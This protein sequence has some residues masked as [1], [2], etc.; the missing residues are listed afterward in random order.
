VA[1]SDESK[2]RLQVLKEAVGLGVG[3]QLAM[4]DLEIRGAGTLLGEKQSGHLTAIG[5][6]LY[7]KLLDRNLQAVRGIKL[8]D[9]SLI[10]LKDV[11]NVFIP[12]S[13]IVDDQQRL[14]MYRRFLASKTPIHLKKLQLECVDRFGRAPKQLDAFIQAIQRILT[15]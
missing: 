11:P 3:Y 7:C 6:D 15:N 9:E 4:K 14:A 13:Y 1:L 8:D 10:S 5:F 2:A 12:S